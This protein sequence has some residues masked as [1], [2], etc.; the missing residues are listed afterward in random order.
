MRWL[1]PQQLIVLRPDI[2]MAEDGLGWRQA[3][4]LDTRVNTG[5]GEVRLITDGRGYRV[6]GRLAG[7]PAS[8]VLALGDSFIAALQVEYEDTVTAQLERSASSALSRRVEVVN[9]AVGGYGPS[10]YLLLA[11]SE[12]AR[13]FYDLVLV[14]LFAGNDVEERKVASFPP[15]SSRR[16]PLR[17]PTAFSRAGLV[18]SWAYP[19][20]D[21]LEARSH[22]F[23]L[24]KN[25]L[26]SVLM[27]AGL[28]ARRFPEVLLLPA[29]ES[30]RWEITAS[31]CEEIAEEAAAN[32]AASYFVLIPGAYQV[33]EELARGYARALRIDWSSVS[34]DQP[35]QLL[36]PALERRGLTVL[37][38]L[39][40]LR[41]RAAS[42]P[43]PLYGSVDTH[44]SPAGHAALAELVLP[45]V[46]GRL[47]GRREGISPE[48][49]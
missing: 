19:V 14:F 28:S 35:S 29:A 31:I 7:S 11:R 4:H 38:A 27:G 39:P 22:L 13:Q 43:E 36:V 10:H 46:I 37:D 12:L 49:R 9:T 24:F 17:W 6:G 8:R 5:E 32:G 42:D 33:E 20:N 41:R 25:R 34:L 47:S 48:N 2:W 23:V 1:A 16:R 3:S 21:L 15:R 44:L 40:E 26:W 30:S 45:E 18:D